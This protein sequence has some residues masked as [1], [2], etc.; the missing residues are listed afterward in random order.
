MEVMTHIEEVFLKIG[1]LH[2]KAPARHQLVKVGLKGPMHT[3]LI[4]RQYGIVRALNP[5]LYNIQ[6]LPVSY[7]PWDV[8]R[9]PNRELS[10][11]RLVVACFVESNVTMPIASQPFK[12]PHQERPI[13]E[14]SADSREEPRVISKIPDS[15][16]AL[17]DDSDDVSDE[18][19]PQLPDGSVY[20]RSV[21]GGK[22]IIRRTKVSAQAVV[23]TKMVRQVKTI[24]QAP[25]IP[26]QGKENKGARSL[27]PTCPTEVSDSEE[28]NQV[29]PKGR[30]KVAK[31]IRH[32]ASP[33][34]RSV[35]AIKQDKVIVKNTTLPHSQWTTAETRA[36]LRQLEASH[37]QWDAVGM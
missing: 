1:K 15:G 21:E 32:S 29:R 23:K 26:T 5:V 24:Q 8:L 7:K 19:L 2:L 17:S 13:E 4:N 12:E 27:V 37:I 30:K 16:N 25:M 10:K 6:A 9:R 33:V 35:L 20:I 28:D 11:A 34:K 31:E 3:E 18:D 36:K 14:I 22:D